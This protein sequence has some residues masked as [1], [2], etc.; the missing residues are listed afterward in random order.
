MASLS[1]FFVNRKKIYNVRKH[2]RCKICASPRS[3]VSKFGLC[4]IH[5]RDLLRTMQIPG[6]TKKTR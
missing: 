5:V 4:R 1:K 6:W 2:N 3:Y